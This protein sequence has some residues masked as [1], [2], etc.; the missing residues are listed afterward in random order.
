[1]ILRIV[2]GRFPEGIDADTLVDL[3]GR[4]TRS[5][6]AIK[7]LESL[8][9]GGRRRPEGAAQATDDER[10]IESMIAPVWRDVETM[11][12]SATNEEEAWFLTSRLDLPFSV[13]RTDHYELVERTFAALP[14]E[15]AA[16]VRF[17]TIRARK[18][19]EARL[20]ETLRY[21]G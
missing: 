1:M 12:R 20:V 7:G 13:E 15:S 2:L 17:V 5:A 11:T 14:P 19:E 10:V 9:V 4:L 6:R 21:Q 16:I 8:V 18:N 3:R